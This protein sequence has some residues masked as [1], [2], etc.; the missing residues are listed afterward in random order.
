MWIESEHMLTVPE[1][2][3]EQRARYARNYRRFA[4]C[5]LVFGVL[6]LGLGL[7]S[8]LSHRDE[9][10]YQLFLLIYG[11]ALLVLSWIYYK[12]AKKYA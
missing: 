6:N 8:V 1:P 9:L 7:K 5:W 10:W 12:R 4:V 2:T 11:V 3:A